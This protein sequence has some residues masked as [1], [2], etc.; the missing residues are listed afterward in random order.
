[1]HETQLLDALAVL[2]DRV[3]QDSRQL[4]RLTNS[5]DTPRLSQHALFQARHAR[6]HLHQAVIELMR[7]Q[8]ILKGEVK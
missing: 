3:D 7:L 6:S 2:L 5:P 8:Q 1:M 4:D